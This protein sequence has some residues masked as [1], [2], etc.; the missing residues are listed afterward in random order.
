MTDLRELLGS[1]LVDEP[2]TTIDPYAALATGRSRRRTR[3]HRLLAGGAAAVVVLGVVAAVGLPRLGIPGSEPSSPSSSTPSAA[4]IGW[5]RTGPAA[6]TGLGLDVARTLQQLDGAAEQVQHLLGLPAL[7][8]ARPYDVPSRHGALEL[9]YRAGGGVEVHVLLQ[10]PEGHPIADCAY[11]P[12]ATPDDW[13]A[14]ASGIRPMAPNLCGDGVSVATTDAGD[15]RLAR[16]VAAWGTKGGQ[17]SVTVTSDADSPPPVSLAAARSVVDLLA[18][19][20]AFQD[21]RAQ[22]ELH[23]SGAAAAAAL[24]RAAAVGADVLQSYP[25]SVRQ[26]RNHTGGPYPGTSPAKEPWADLPGTDAA[27]WCVTENAG[28]YRI[29]AA[30]GGAGAVTFVTSTSPLSTD[31]NG[32]VVP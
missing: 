17:L 11:P 13:P 25:T 1:T 5:V 15:G 3:R 12:P 30:T 18:A 20:M 8:A 2:P 10:G 32:P 14:T 19:T 26:V 6:E 24:C 29:V 7:D 22:S 23:E 16:T 31:E 21:D 4:S 27:A 28:T 9:A